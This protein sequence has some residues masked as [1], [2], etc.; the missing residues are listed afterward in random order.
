LKAYKA[1]PENPKYGY[2]YA[3]YL[4]EKGDYRKAISVLNDLI[5]V[6]SEYIDAYVFLANIYEVH[7]EFKEALE[8]YE[9]ADKI[10]GLPAEY[11]Q[12]IQMRMTGI[13]Q[14]IQ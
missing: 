10:P 2:T 13:R 5:L 9:K 1:G 12:S 4:N 3:F 6:H 14:R 11:R 7:Q 8:V